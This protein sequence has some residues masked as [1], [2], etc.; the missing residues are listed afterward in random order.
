MCI[1]DVHWCRVLN[2]DA[3]RAANWMKIHVF[4]ECHMESV[5]VVSAFLSDS[6][7][8]ISRQDLKGLP[9]FVVFQAVFEENTYISFIILLIIVH[10]I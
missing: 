4:P 2:F 7:S 5:V 3:L 8:R 6:R 1:Y 10:M 9:F